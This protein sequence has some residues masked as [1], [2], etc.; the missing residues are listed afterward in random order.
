MSGQS[1]DRHD[2]IGKLSKP[3]ANWGLFLS[4]DTRKRA[5][6]QVGLT[7][8]KSPGGFENLVSSL[9]SLTSLQEKARPRPRKCLETLLRY[10]QEGFFVL[11]SHPLGEDRMGAQ[12]LSNNPASGQY[13]EA[14]L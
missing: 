13:W 9:P 5:T 2:R 1:L 7:L 6:Y 3:W 12:K 4:C 11:Q 10:L 14:G 8:A